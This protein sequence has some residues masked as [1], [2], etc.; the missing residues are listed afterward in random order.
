MAKNTG[1]GTRIGII[2]DRTQVYNEKTGKYVKRN[3]TTGQFMGSKKTPY[4]AI[5][6]EKK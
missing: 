2:A 4:K 1:N 5:R 6:V 3:T